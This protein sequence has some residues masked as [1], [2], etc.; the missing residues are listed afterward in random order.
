[1]WQKLLAESRLLKIVYIY[2][3]FDIDGFDEQFKAEVET[4]FINRVK[5]L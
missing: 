3:G 5:I 2:L 4:I 1:M